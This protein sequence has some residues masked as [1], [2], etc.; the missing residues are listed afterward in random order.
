MQY[1]EGETLAARLA[2]GRL[3]FDEVLRLAIDTAEAL[4]RAHQVGVIHRDLNTRSSGGSS[5]WVL[6][7]GNDQP[8]AQ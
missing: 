1:L 7:L 4:G 6:R 5:L 3:S 2:R 8:D